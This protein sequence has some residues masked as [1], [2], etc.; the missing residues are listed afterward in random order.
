MIKAT[1]AALRYD[2]NLRC[3]L[4]SSLAS[5]YLSRPWIRAANVVTLSRNDCSVGS[6][7][8]IAHIDIQKRLGRTVRLRLPCIGIG[9]Q[10]WG[11]DT[12]RRTGG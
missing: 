6:H 11:R 7:G 2:W 1:T 12:V 10:A 4:R 3:S 9:A 8:D 5:S